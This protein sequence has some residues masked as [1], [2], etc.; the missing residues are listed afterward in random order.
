MTVFTQASK[1][2]KVQTFPKHCWSN[3]LLID[4]KNF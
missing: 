3:F 1:N 2:E 4:T